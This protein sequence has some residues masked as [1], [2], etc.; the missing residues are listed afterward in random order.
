MSGGGD[1]HESAAL[2]QFVCI[3]VSKQRDLENAVDGAAVLL[4]VS[5]DNGS[6]AEIHGAVC[7]E[8][9]TRGLLKPN[10]PCL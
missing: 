6:L 3:H 10:T 4:V 1:G 8:L 9:Q 7:E 2:H 5:P